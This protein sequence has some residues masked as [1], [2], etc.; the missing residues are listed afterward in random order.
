V[1]SQTYP[2]GSAGGLTAIEERSAVETHS[3]PGPWVS[4]SFHKYNDVC[5]ERDGVEFA[6]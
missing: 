5:G 2:Q 3:R 4:A 6:K 1:R